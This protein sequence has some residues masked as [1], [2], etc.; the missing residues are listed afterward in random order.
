[1]IIK[2]LYSSQE[3][4][5]GLHLVWD[6]F[7]REN[8]NSCTQQGIEEFARFIKMENF[9]PLVESGEMIVFGAVEEQDLGGVGAVRRDGHISLLF[10]RPDLRRKGIAKALVGEMC[11]YC[12][13]Q[14]A[15]MRMT[16]NA[17]VVSTEAYHHMGFRDLAPVQEKNGIRFVPMDLMIS[18]ANVR[19]S[20]SGEGKQEDS[21]QIFEYN[22]DEDG[23]IDDIF[24]SNGNEED[25]KDSSS[26]EA[27]GIEAIEGYEAENLPYTITEEN[28]T[29]FSNGNKGEYPMQFD[30]KY[31][32]I[33]GVEG[34]NIDKI[35]EMLKDC[36][37]S[38]VNTLYLAPSDSMKE[39]MLEE[40]NPFLGSLVTY[41]VSYAGEDFISVA[42]NDIYYAGNTSAQYCDLRT[43]NIRISDAKQ[44][45]VADIVDLSDAF[46]HDWMK[47]MKGEAPSA[48]V[49][50]SVKLND[51]RQIL[52]G[53]ILENRYFDAFFVDKDGIEIGITYH[54][55]GDGK[56]SSAESGWITAPFTMKEIIEYKT[57]SEFWNLVQSN[58]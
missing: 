55:P 47:K 49:L 57:D 7:I 31:P 1:M 13:M 50:S 51:F 38:T 19:S 33:T 10:V 26:E 41:K 39:K 53:E 8:A 12:T 36:A 40:S 34:E 11:R 35:N 20:Y 3:V 43:R 2:R 18:P 9:M 21:S 4:V 58:N 52:N 46:M 25:N 5:E 56:K 44:F 30:V 29:Y 23:E 14:F 32:Q 48:E 16:V 28:Y 45:E 37:M 42:F 27:Q 17:S 15:L 54:Y 24:G 6:V 22:P